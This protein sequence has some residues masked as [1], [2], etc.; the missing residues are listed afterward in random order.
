M[1]SE[2]SSDSFCF[3]DFKVIYLKELVIE[4]FQVTMEKRQ[5]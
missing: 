3:N 4:K 2:K 1:F 5:N